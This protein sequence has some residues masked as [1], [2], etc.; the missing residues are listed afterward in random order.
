[1]PNP[2]DDKKY[3]YLW[4]CR[5]QLD[6]VKRFIIATDSDGPGKALAEELARRLG[7]ERCFTVN[8]PEG[9]KDANE[10]LQSGGIELI[11]D[12]I[13]SAEGF[14]LRGLFKFADFSGDIEQYFN[15]DAG[16]EL[17]GVSTGWRSVDKHYRVVP[18]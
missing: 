16:S 17:R 8:W 5:A 13:S 6:T 15:M 3:E 18:G 9:C 11:R 4:N 1:M 2:E 10:T 14:P 7:K 12:S